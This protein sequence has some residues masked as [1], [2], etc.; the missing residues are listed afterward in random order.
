MRRGRGRGLGFNRGGGGAGESYDADA[1]AYF[2]A[3]TTQPTSAQK[4]ILNK[5]IVDLK[6]A[7]TWAKILSLYFFDIHSEADAL[8]DVKRPAATKATNNAMTFNYD[9]T[10]FTGGTGKYINTNWAMNTLFASNNSM[11][12]FAWG[13]NSVAEN[14]YLMGGLAYALVGIK[15]RTTSVNKPQFALSCP[16]AEV[17]SATSVD[18]TADGCFLVTRVDGVTDIKAF[19]NGV[20]LTLSVTSQSKYTLDA[21]KMYFGALNNND[22]SVVQ[23]TSG[24]IKF[25]GAGNNMTAGDATALYDAIRLN[26]MS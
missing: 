14:T 15:A 18:A 2:A 22:S 13:T 6:A 4:A 5:R 20:E 16:S 11:S 17:S 24:K 21:V 19:R 1:V 8:I 9:F 12:L 25:G 26:P 7:G 10:G 23:A 3:M